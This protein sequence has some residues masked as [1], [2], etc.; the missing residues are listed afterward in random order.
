M[1]PKKFE[2]ENLAAKVKSK[3]CSVNASLC[4]SW[5]SLD[6][7]IYFNFISFEY[8]QGEK[9]NWPYFYCSIM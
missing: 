6:G 1:V 4:D 8:C 5:H 3:D 7:F 9:L 2:L